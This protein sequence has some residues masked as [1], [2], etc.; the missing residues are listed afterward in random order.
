M[1]FNETYPI[2][3]METL[4]IS[5]ININSFHILE[6]NMDITDINFMPSG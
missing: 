1:T 2:I 5:R 6:I 3:T 4:I